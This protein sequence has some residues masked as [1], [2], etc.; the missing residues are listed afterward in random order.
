ME[1]IESSE[2]SLI[3]PRPTLITYSVS[4]CDSYV[5]SDDESPLIDVDVETN[6]CYTREIV[7]NTLKR[8]KRVPISK[9]GKVL[10]HCH[11]AKSFPAIRG[12][13]SIVNR[14]DF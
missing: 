5:N 8:S 11:C 3:P 9:R 10:D 13:D 4:F 14:Y 6:E 7:E 12:T 1:H 2:G